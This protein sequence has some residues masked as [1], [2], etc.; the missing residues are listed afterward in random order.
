M[1]YILGIVFML[2]SS[3]GI[4]QDIVEWDVHYNQDSSE[5]HFTATI[6][7]GWHL[8][9]QHVDI[10]FGPIPTQFEI[11]PSEGVTLEGEVQEPT[12][13]TEVDPNF[14]EELSFFKY[15][16]TF[17]QEVT[18]SSTDASISGS[19]TYMVCNDSMC[20]PPTDYFFEIELK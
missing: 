18:T 3:I 5:V 17:I 14:D 13:Y 1:Q 2:I 11:Q 19:I 6:A 9:S 20:M 12:P 15:S 4:S 8:Y 7:D 10:E 16:V